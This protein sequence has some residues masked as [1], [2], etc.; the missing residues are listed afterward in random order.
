VFKRA[1]L[2]SSH[3]SDKN[4]SNYYPC[5]SIR[6][7]LDGYYR[8]MNLS[9]LRRLPDEVAESFKDYLDFHCE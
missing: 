1:V 3:A 5:Q 7:N 6:E 8:A 4:G 9:S 2:L